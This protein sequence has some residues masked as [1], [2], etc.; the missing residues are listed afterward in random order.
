MVTRVVLV[1]LCTVAGFLFGLLFSQFVLKL[2]NWLDAKLVL[3]LFSGTGFVIGHIY[4]K[5]K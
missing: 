5:G 4:A 3:T 2:D 1:W